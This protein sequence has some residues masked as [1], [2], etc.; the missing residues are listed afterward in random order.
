MENVKRCNGCSQDKP[1]EDFYWTDK[2]HA[3]RAGPCK[4][5]ISKRNAAWYAALSPEAK[6]RRQDYNR[7]YLQRPIQLRRQR[8]WRYR[9]TYQMTLV[10][11]E[12]MLAAQGGGCAICRST[13][14]LHVDHDH[15]CCPGKTSCGRCIR[16]ILCARCNTGRGQV[17][18]IAWLEA[19]IGYLRTYQRRTRPVV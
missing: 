4:A 9:K 2:T 18:N 3:R 19:R 11:Y 8:N 5:C 14:Y 13:E 17:D 6:Q 15:G 12:A 10:Q 7:D 16:G 1:E